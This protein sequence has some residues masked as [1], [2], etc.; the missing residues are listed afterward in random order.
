MQYLAL[1]VLLLLSLRMES[2][3]GS[4]VCRALVPAF[5][6]WTPANLTYST[7]PAQMPGT[8]IL[9]GTY[10]VGASTTPGH[11]HACTPVPMYL[12]PCRQLCM[13]FGQQQEHHHTLPPAG[14]SHPGPPASTSEPVPIFPLPASTRPMFFFSPPELPFDI[15]VVLC[16]ISSPDK[17]VFDPRCV[18]DCAL[19]AAAVAGA[20]PSYAPEFVFPLGCNSLILHTNL[21]SQGPDD[22]TSSSLLLSSRS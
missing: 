12:L 16:A 20:Q 5:P 18:L 3:E 4:G 10:C 8:E 2:A 21:P 6:L 15:N 22:D 11:L 13:Y 1:V 9:G 7:C 19:V 14:T 17:P